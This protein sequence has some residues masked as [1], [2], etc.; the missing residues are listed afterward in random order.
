MRLSFARAGCKS[1]NFGVESGSP[2]ILEGVRRIRIP[3]ERIRR[4]FDTCREVGIE[5]MA[6]F[7]VGLPGET[8]STLEATVRLA[9]EL[10]PDTAQFTAATPY[11]D[12]PYYE[13]MKQQGL[14]KQDWSLFTSRAPVVGTREL[15]PE[16]LGE[17][18]AKAY[19][20]FYFRPAYVLMRMKKLRSRH[21]LARLSSG[22]RS[23]FKYAGIF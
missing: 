4:I 9:I 20:R 11:P 2:E 1:I 6:F 22:I 15:N 5:T 3:R 19:R 23:A 17:L 21:E 8:E 14:L 7:I 10:N 16:K 13:Q 18:I 12:T